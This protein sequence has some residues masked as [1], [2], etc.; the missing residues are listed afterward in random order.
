MWVEAYKIL[1]DLLR[2]I[3]EGIEVVRASTTYFVLDSED[4]LRSAV[5]GEGRHLFLCRVLMHKS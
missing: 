1:A 5:L 2:G 4:L 3:G